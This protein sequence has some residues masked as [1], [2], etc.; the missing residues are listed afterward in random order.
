MNSHNYYKIDLDI[1][2]TDILELCTGMN[3][4]KDIFQKISKK[5][6]FNVQDKECQNIFNNFI[7]EFNDKGIISFL[8]KPRYN[9]N[10]NT[11][12]RGCLYPYLAVIEITN[13]C[14]FQCDHCYKNAKKH[15]GIFLDYSKI[16][17]ILDTLRNKTPCLNITGGEPL[18]HPE[19]ENII[20]CANDDFKTSLLT[21]GYI[22]SEFEDKILKYVKTIQISIYG[23][24]DIEYKNNVM[25]EKGFSKLIKGIEKVKKRNIFICAT[26]ILN[27]N[28]IS[29]LDECCY[30]LSKYKIDILRF[31]ISLP[32]GK[33]IKSTL[34]NKFI[35]NQTELY[36]IKK[37]I[38]ILKDKYNEKIKF[39]PY[40][41][42]EFLYIENNNKV[43]DEE[44]YKFKC[45]AGRYIVTIS[46]KGKVR[47]CNMLPEEIF[48]MDDYDTYFYNIKNGNRYSFTQSM[49]KFEIYLLKNNKTFNDI[50][51]I[52]CT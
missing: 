2:G 52:G 13:S 33:L 44:K 9:T 12:K 1:V 46:E 32:V 29:K 8:K 40:G 47:P 11:G 42:L 37:E 28:N 23:N 19:I 21:N 48:N 51:C 5:Y 27:K 17:V 7:K 50:K 26:I 45:S 30:Q 34:E 6:H 20:L 43:P 16:K 3:T 49:K 31:G 10:I 15:T 14:N 35:F 36:A 25:V 22:L 4:L 41:D 38:D 24:N 18:L 39:Y